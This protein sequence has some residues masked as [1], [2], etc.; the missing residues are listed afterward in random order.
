MIV[1]IIVTLYCFTQV[2][3]SHLSEQDCDNT[4][5]IQG[6]RFGEN[7]DFS[8]YSI[9]VNNSKGIDFR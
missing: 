5:P 6:Y 3:K 7:A 2:I 9:F 1:I 4:L 8:R